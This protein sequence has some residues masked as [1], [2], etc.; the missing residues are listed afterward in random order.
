MR[1]AVSRCSAPSSAYLFFSPQAPDNRRLVQMRSAD[2]INFI[3]QN[4]TPDFIRLRAPRSGQALSHAGGQKSRIPSSFLARRK[5]FFADLGQ[6]ARRQALVFSAA[7]PYRAS[8][9]WQNRY[10]RAKR[11]ILT[12]ARSRAVSSRKYRANAFAAAMSIHSFLIIAEN[13]AGEKLNMQVFIRGKIRLPPRILPL[14]HTI[15]QPVNSPSPL[16]QPS[17]HNSS[18]G[19]KLSVFSRRNIAS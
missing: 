14:F 7:P 19:S 2:K 5:N 4:F 16:F 13:R 18:F 17:F 6:S 11:V 15:P 10:V 8:P 9:L 12:A 3:L 1:L